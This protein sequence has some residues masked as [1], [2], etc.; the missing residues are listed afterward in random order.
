MNG[1]GDQAE[2][3][4]NPA[5]RE[6]TKKIIDG[7]RK[8]PAPTAPPFDVSANVAGISVND[9]LSAGMK[10]SQLSIHWFTRLS[11]ADKDTC[12]M[13]LLPHLSFSGRDEWR[14]ITYAFHSLP[15]PEAQTLW[16]DWSQSQPGYN[17][18]EN[19]KLWEGI[20]PDKGITFL[21]LFH[22][23]RQGGWDED[24]WEMK[25]LNAQPAIIVPAPSAMVI[26]SG[27]TGHIDA[28]MTH[29]SF[30]RRFNRDHHGEFRFNKTMGVWKRW[31]GSVWASDDRGMAHRIVTEKVYAARGKMGGKKNKG[32]RQRLGVASFGDNVL[33]ASETMPGFVSIATDY[34]QDMW[35]LGVP[36]DYVDLRTG[37]LRPPDPA[38]MISKSTKVAPA[39]GTPALWLKFLGEATGGDKDFEEYLQK[40]CG[41]FLTG[42]VEEEAFW[43]LY[44]L[45]RNGKG[46][47]VGAV[48]NIMH[49]YA[50]ETPSSTFLEQRNPEHLTEV[51]RLDGA[52]L[53]L[54]SELPENA[55]WNAQRLK[56]MTGN[57][58]KMVGRFMRQDFFEFYFRGKLLFVGN[59]KPSLRNVDEAI[60]RR[61]NLLPFELTPPAPDPGLKAKL[62]AEYPQIL[63]WMIDGAVNYHQKGLQ[64]PVVVQAASDEYMS[65]EDK[66][67][68]FLNDKYQQDP[69]GNIPVKKVLSDY[70]VFCSGSTTR[71]QINSSQQMRKLLE[72]RGH[73]VT[74]TNVG[75]ALIGFSE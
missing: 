60:R 54:V 50:L 53:V 9:D 31:D 74:K 66:L 19:K 69:N 26:A 2:I 37:E 8:S 75:Q 14:D 25:A 68:C 42:S 44:G 67:E 48:R 43:F 56:E 46:V 18:G 63:Q 62:I 33:R 32:T 45:G 39:S 6:G 64:P 57:E 17:A 5:I 59:T 72:S 49:D 40:L 15:L 24:P 34:D 55:I 4:S 71:Q 38:M 3:V 51:A 1:L 36:S 65:S 73:T 41:L 29:D 21:S 52:R 28:D 61:F 30:A 35:A 11:D 7:L 70:Q 27:G 47:F 22:N 20:V 23:A 16:D 10:K 13:S 12:I 58:A